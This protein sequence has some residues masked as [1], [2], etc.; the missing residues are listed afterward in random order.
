MR[1]S[2]Y[3]LLSV[4]VELTYFVNQTLAILRYMGVKYLQY[5]IILTEEN[6]AYNAWI[7]KYRLDILLDI[8]P[9]ISI[10]SRYYY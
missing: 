1:S 9:L 4:I 6:H 8:D 3:T 2:L 5:Q 10:A 7:Q